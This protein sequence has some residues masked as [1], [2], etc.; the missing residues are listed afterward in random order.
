MSSTDDQ[1]KR[2]CEFISDQLDREDARRVSLDQRALAVITSSGA[3]TTLLFAVVTATRGKDGV[4][5]SST[6]RFVIATVVLLVVSAL[7]ALLATKLL[8][9]TVTSVSTLRAML[10]SPHWQDDEVD[11]RNATATSQV[12]SVQTLRDGNDKKANYVVVSIGFQALAFVTLTF[13]V[14]TSL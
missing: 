13:A 4:L 6:S 14:V 2:Y 8:G 5:A 1:G 12:N 9:Y 7:C 3:F 11:A 10:A